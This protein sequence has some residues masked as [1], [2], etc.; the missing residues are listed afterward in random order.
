MMNDAMQKVIRWEYIIGCRLR[1][2][3]GSPSSAEG[4][5]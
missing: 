2:K 4:V 5:K 3:L 1:L